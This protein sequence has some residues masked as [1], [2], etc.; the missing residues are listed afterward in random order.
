M[1]KIPPQTKE[2]INKIR[3]QAEKELHF[4]KKHDKYQADKIKAGLYGDD[5]ESDYFEENIIEE[6]FI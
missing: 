2:E 1:I 3:K 4:L 6:G 5:Y